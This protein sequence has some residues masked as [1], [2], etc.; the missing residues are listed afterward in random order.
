MVVLDILRF[1]SLTR[2]VPLKAVIRSIINEDGMSGYSGYRQSHR[3]S[4]GRVSVFAMQ[5]TIDR[6]K[7]RTHDFCD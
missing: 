7:S 2:C 5:K 4:P 3:S 1:E 6:T